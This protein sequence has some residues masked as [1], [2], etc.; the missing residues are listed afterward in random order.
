MESRDRLADTILREE[1][2]RL[3]AHLPKD[4]RTLK[5]LLKEDLP[6]VPTVDGGEIIMKRSEL[7]QLASSLP[8]EL[9]ERVRL[10]LVFLRRTELGSG[11]F[12]LIG[13]SA[14]E[15]VLSRIAQGYAGSYDDFRKTPGG[16]HLFF[17]PEV[18]DLMRRFHTLLVIGFGVPENRR[19]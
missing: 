14:E 12:T 3:N 15:F 13:D 5:E 10:P 11:A 8:E 2:R 6:S 19:D 17:K 9:T 7:E 1:M 4:R 18:S 16:N